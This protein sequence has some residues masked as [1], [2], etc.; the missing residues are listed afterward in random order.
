M[1]D[2]TGH[3]QINTDYEKFFD[4]FDPPR[5][6]KFPIAIGLPQVA[7]DLLLVMCTMI[8][9][10]IKIGK[11]VGK[12]FS[13][14]RG[15]GQGDSMSLFAALAITTIQFRFVN[16]ECPKV[17]LGSV[18]DD[19]NFRG[20]CSEVIRQCATPYNLTRMLG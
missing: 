16:H 7:A 15:F 20:Q 8:Q 3:T 6:H 5:F 19:R 17:Q 9:R 4:T 10:R 18:I 14:N 12:V 2:R 13:S 1:L 11:H